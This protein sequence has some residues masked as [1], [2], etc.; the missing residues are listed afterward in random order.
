M[1]SFPRDFKKASKLE[2]SLQ[3]DLRQKASFEKSGKSTIRIK[4]TI[5]GTIRELEGEVENLF[6]VFKS[7][8]ANRNHGLDETEIAKREKQLNSLVERFAGLKA[9]NGGAGGE[10]GVGIDTHK[11][12]YED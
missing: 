9:K 7:Y 12:E 3:Q 6:N 4:A 5:R 2:K 8:S 10:G 11:K 1:D